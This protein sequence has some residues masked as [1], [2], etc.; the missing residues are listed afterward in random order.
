[1]DAKDAKINAEKAKLVPILSKERDDAI[2]QRNGA[3]LD[4]HKLEEIW[5]AQGQ[6]IERLNTELGQRYEL[7]TL[8]GVGGTA[9]V[10]GALAGVL[11]LVFA[12]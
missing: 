10:V 7:G 1:M 8:F 6:E 3:I 5:I 12:Q 2:R 11:I 9:L 4:K